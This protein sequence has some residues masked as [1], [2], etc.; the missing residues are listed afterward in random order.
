MTDNTLLAEL[1]VLADRPMTFMEVCGTHTMAAAR[2]G[3]RSL[4]PPSLRLISGPGCPVCVTPVGYVDHALALAATTGVTVATFGD[5]VRVPGS[6]RP[7]A[8]APPSLQTARA[9]GADIHVVLS[10]AD[11]LELARRQP[12]RQVVMLGVG[13]ETTAPA[14]AATLRQARDEGVHNYSV[15]SAHKTIPGAMQLLA[16]SGELGLDGFLCPGHV[17]VIIGPE[18]YEPLAQ[19]GIPCAIAGF[20]PEEMLRG[21][22]ALARQVRDGEA[23]VDNTYP[24]VV[25]AGG[26]P[27]A[28]RWLEEVFTPCDSNWRGIGMIPDSGLTLAEAFADHDAARRFQVQ[29]PPAVEP[30]DC[31]CGDVLRGVLD[32]TECPL[33]GGACTPES[34][35]GA[36]MVSSEGSCAAR[37]LY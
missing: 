4:L 14:V 7:G 29:L 9:S 2:A 19:Q 33:F 13:F 23:R 17:S 8:K 24:A 6:R 37:Y 32:P 12:E 30:P 28:R 27:V 15:L 18:A 36:C 3:L 1:K 22:V 21:I 31:R 25:R 10:P 16:S 11:A 20:E 5:M 35:Q 26:N 34:P